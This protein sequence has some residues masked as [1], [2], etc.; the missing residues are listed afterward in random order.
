MH[1]RRSFLE[2]IAASAGVLGVGATAGCLGS[3]PGL[4]GGGG[5]GSGNAPG[6]AGR[7]YEPSEVADLPTRLFAS[8][9][10]ATLYER[11]DLYPDSLSQQLEMADSASDA[12]TVSEL[13]QVTGYGIA[14]ENPQSVQTGQGQAAG[15]VMVSGS[16]DS[17]ALVEQLQAQAGTDASLE[18]AGSANGHDLY[19]AT[20]ATDQG[21]TAL[22]VSDESV[23]VGGTSGVDATGEDAVRAMLSASNAGYYS[24]SDDAG[25]LIDALGDPTTVVGAEFDPG[26][27]A[28][29]DFEG[30]PGGESL[31][32]V[33]TGLTAAGTAMTLG[34]D[35][36]E[37]DVVA[38]YEQGEAPTEDQVQDLL[39]LAAA[40]AANQSPVGGD[41][42]ALQQLVQDMEPSVDGRT[43]TVSVSR[44]TEGLFQSD[45]PRTPVSPEAAV[46]VAPGVAVLGTFIL[47]IGG[48]GVG[49]GP[50]GPAG[51]PPRVQFDFSY[52]S[53]TGQV[54]VTHAG[55]DT[56]S[57]EN[58]G[59]V[60]VTVNG[61]PQAA[62][63]LPV[64][65]GDSV[66]VQA[67]SGAT[68]AVVWTGPDGRTRQTL[69]VFEVP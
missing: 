48:G 35:T 25:R 34:Q 12:V 20:G 6:Y 18:D 16:F 24:S 14:G 29:E 68:I 43:L 56:M 4:G 22:A 53:G 65:A 30:Q 52:D 3:V 46:L 5:G 11:R 27:F 49:G 32:A 67:D 19:T 15:S 60:E 8:Y 39:D 23:F 59:Q 37:R 47:G 44:D 57:S 54:Q 2:R 17:G 64:T 1:S 63:Q 9:D 28:S 41:G 66:T 42:A 55:G 50:G 13:D 26:E 31:R 61:Q 69:G 58:T 40:A 51:R 7:L 21:S 38:V 36:V 10:V 33:L 45:N 62:F